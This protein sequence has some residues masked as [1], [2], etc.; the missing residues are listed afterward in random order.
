MKCIFED[1]NS[2]GKLKL[3]LVAKTNATKQSDKPC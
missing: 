1:E 3:E 2:F